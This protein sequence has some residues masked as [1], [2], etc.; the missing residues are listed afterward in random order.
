MK[1]NED[2]IIDTVEKPKPFSAA[3]SLSRAAAMLG[4]DE[5]EPPEEPVK[6]PEPA[7]EVPEKK[8]DTPLPEKT[9]TAPAPKFEDL[10]KEHGINSVD[11]LKA[12]KAKV[13]EHKTLTEEVQK[14]KSEKEKS[15]FASE[16]IEKLNK[17]VA[18]G[19][20]LD[21]IKAF[22]KINDLGDLSKADPKAIKLLA[23]QMREQ[24]TEKEAEKLL[25]RKY[26]TEVTL[27][28]DEEGYDQAVEDAEMAQ[29]LLKTEVSQDRE[30]I[31]QYQGTLEAI[32]PAGKQEA[33]S[34]QAQQYQDN[35]DKIIPT[36]GSFDK[37]ENININ[38][39]K[40]EE[41]VVLPEFNFTDETKKVATDLVKGFMTRNNLE[42]TPDNLQ[43]AKQFALDMMFLAEKETIVVAAANHLASIKVK[44]I[45]DK[46]NNPQEIDR[47]KMGKNESNEDNEYE[48]WKKENLKGTNR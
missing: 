35:L 41:A 6:Q 7:K 22:E 18:S 25:S 12:F 27:D 24:L 1:T 30:Y 31:K 44:E 43:S 21:Q 14:L 36:L 3:D 28:K 37:L 11:E 42:I 17:L 8:N 48:Q 26:K 46:Y 13:E 29:L 23:L 10:L 16:K 40:N 15:P 20:T 33:D 5:P 19:A 2:P 34:I 4:G 47:S 38:G 39:K 9:D 45:L 32:D